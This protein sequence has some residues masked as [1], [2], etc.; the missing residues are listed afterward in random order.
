MEMATNWQYSESFAETN[1]TML[2]NKA[3]CDVIFAAGNEQKQIKCHKFFLAS[4]SP[5]FYAMFCGGT[6][7]ESKDIIYVP[8]IESTTLDHLK[9]WI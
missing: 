5:V 8:D 9:R 2:E 4:R 1:L 6:L 7:A 3:L